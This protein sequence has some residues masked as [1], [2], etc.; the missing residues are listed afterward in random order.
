M[1]RD[2]DWLLIEIQQLMRQVFQAG[3]SLCSIA[4]KLHF[5]NIISHSQNLRNSDVIREDTAL[6]QRGEIQYSKQLD[7]SYLFS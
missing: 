3:I 1:T 6:E 2:L 5:P 7:L 4:K